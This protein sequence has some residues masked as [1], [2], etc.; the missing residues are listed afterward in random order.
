MGLPC[1]HVPDCPLYKMQAREQ[2]LL[3]ALQT[4]Q[5]EAASARDAFG[6]LQAE[7]LTGHDCTSVATV[8]ALMQTVRPTALRTLTQPRGPCGQVHNGLRP[9]LAAQAQR[10][11]A[12]EAE[13]GAARASAY[14]AE[15]AASATAAALVRA[16]DALRCIGTHQ[17]F[18][19]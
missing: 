14:E 4:A 3:A 19:S 18:Q 13:A 10:L 1:L 8:A 11:D 17:Y 2:Q 7:V 16:Q 6:G 5:Q 9:A 15:H 12:A